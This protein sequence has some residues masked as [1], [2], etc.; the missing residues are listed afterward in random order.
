MNPLYS[1]NLIFYCIMNTFLRP[2]KT[3]WCN[4]YILVSFLFIFQYFPLTLLYFD[5][6]LSLF[7]ILILSSHSFIFLYFPSLFH[8]SILSSHSLIF[9][10]FP[11]TLSY[12]DTFL[13][14]SHILILSSHYFIFWYFSLTYSY[15]DAFLSALTYSYF[16]TLTYSEFLSKMCLVYCLLGCLVWTPRPG[17]I[18]RNTGCGDC[19]CVWTQTISR[20]R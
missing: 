19:G 3:P 17:N 7:H 12:F 15:F 16:N 20:L 8:I 1:K 4:V 13:S 6:F 18:D 10:Y 14:L 9:R 11:L 5:T 2:W